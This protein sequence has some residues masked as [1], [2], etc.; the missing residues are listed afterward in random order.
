MSEANIISGRLVAADRDRAFAGYRVVALFQEQV[1]LDN[2]DATGRGAEPFLPSRRV[3][4]VKIDGHFQMSLPPKEL[5]QGP[6]SMY[7]QNANGVRLG[8]AAVDPDALEKVEI[9][10]GKDPGPEVIPPSDDP[11]L[12]QRIKFTGRAIDN[13]GNG[14]TPGLMV[15]FWGVPPGG[16]PEDR[17]PVAIAQLTTGGY[18]S[19]TWP[20]DILASAFAQIQGSAPIGVDLDGEHFPRR[21]I[22]VAE[23]P[24]SDGANGSTTPPRAPDAVDLAEN[25]AAFAADPKPCAVFTVPNRTVE[26]V[27]YFA[28]VRTTQPDVQSPFRPPRPLPVPPRLLDHIVDLANRSAEFEIR[29]PS[30]P[31]TVRGGTGLATLA[32]VRPGIA[33]D[34]PVVFTAVSTRTDPITSSLEAATSLFSASSA[35]A[36]PTN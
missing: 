25:P 26:E 15:V 34:A 33:I 8:E 2:G 20:P 23:R 29:V 36:A 3:A 1:A 31:T 16:A 4:A 30:N 6:L 17:F 10:V 21:V 7:A 32:D 5:W 13:Q 22:L 18:F 11:T 14:L 27:T 9:P 24:T 12:G 19:G 28:L 35:T